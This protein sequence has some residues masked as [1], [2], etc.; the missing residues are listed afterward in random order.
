MLSKEEKEEMYL[1]C[2]GGSNLLIYDISN[3]KIERVELEGRGVEL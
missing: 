1:L 3:A 2:L